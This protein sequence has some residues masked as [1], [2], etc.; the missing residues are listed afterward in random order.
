MPPDWPEH[1]EFFQ[2]A[3][4]VKPDLRVTVS[5]LQALILL[6]WYLYTEVSAGS[7][8]DARRRMHG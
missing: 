2:F 3:L 6:H 5:S 4:A 8:D 7:P 1:E